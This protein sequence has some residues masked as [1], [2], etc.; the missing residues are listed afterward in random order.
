M[1]TKKIPSTSSTSS[2]SRRPFEDASWVDFQQQQQKRSPKTTKTKRDFW[3]LTQQQQ[4]K[5]KQQTATKRKQTSKTKRHAGNPE[6]HQTNVWV[7]G[8]LVTVGVTL[9][10]I[11]GLRHK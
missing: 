7:G 3:F 4:K 11:F 1:T 6:K 10:L 8:M 5:F 9:A 2:T